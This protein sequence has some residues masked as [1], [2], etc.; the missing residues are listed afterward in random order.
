[1]KLLLYNCAHY[2]L[3]IRVHFLLQKKKT[4]D[5]MVYYY[6]LRCFHYWYGSKSQ[7]MY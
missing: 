7:T 6:A 3:Y 5:V 2:M 1:M 4:I